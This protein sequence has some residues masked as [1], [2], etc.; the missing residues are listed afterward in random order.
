[1]AH[2]FRC[3]GCQPTLLF[4]SEISDNHTNKQWICILHSRELNTRLWRFPVL[5]QCLENVEIDCDTDGERSRW[6]LATLNFDVSKVAFDKLPT[7]TQLCLRNVSPGCSSSTVNSWH[8]WSSLRL[9]SR[10]PASYACPAEA[11]FCKRAFAALV[12][13]TKSFT[14]IAL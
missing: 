5:G 8:R 12:A 7:S 10:S 14:V 11:I 2:H 3:K 9:A 6:L 4:Y 1:V 13:M